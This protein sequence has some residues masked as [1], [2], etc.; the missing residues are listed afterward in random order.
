ML[1]VHV[2]S[3]ISTSI[4]YLPLVCNVA[5]YTL[6]ETDGLVFVFASDETMA[7]PPQLEQFEPLI[8]VIAAGNV[9]TL[10]IQEIVFVDDTLVPNE[11]STY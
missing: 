10:C 2:R 9:M 6:I 8:E 7:V 11:V 5:G 4:P 3:V 1:R